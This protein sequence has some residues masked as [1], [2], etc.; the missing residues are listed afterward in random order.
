MESVGQ[1][2]GYTQIINASLRKRKNEKEK[3]ITHLENGGGWGESK[4][5]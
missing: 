4:G 2:E 1:C 3:E 5:K